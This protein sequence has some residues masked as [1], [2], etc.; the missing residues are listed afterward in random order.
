MF[1]L[2]LNC[3]QLVLPYDSNNRLYILWFC[4]LVFVVWQ[5]FHLSLA[6]QTVLFMI[7]CNFLV[8]PCIF[9]Y[10]VVLNSPSVFLY[11]SYT[12]KFYTCYKNLRFYCQLLIKFYL[13]T[14]FVGLV[15]ITWQFYTLVSIL[16]F[17]F[18]FKIF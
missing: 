10:M 6:F 11:A 15:F 13:L 4:S 3:C 8:K 16:K 17:L 18:H 2:L 12:L 9:T 7:N 5:L 1:L 14:V